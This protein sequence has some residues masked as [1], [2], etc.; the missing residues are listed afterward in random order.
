MYRLCITVKKLRHVAGP[1]CEET[2]LE[3]PLTG[4]QLLGLRE[5]LVFKFFEYLH[6]LWLE[7]A[8]NI[9]APKRVYNKGFL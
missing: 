2:R 3:T 6:E 9:S 1:V 7:T 4:L 5:K 8:C